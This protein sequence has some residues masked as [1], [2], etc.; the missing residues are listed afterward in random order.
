M[1]GSSPLARGTLL[2][3][4]DLEAEARLIP[5]RAGNMQTLIRTSTCSSAHPRSRGE[6]KKRLRV[7]WTLSRLIPARAGNIHPRRSPP[8]TRTA[9][10]RSRGEHVCIL[11]HL[12]VPVGSSP[13][14]RGTFSEHE[15]EVRARRLIPAR[16]GNI[17]QLIL[18]GTSDAA[19][20]RSRGEHLGLVGVQRDPCGSSP[21]ARGT[22]AYDLAEKIHERLIPARAGNIIFCVTCIMWKTAHPRSRGEHPKSS[23]PASC[24][25]GSSP[26]ARG[27]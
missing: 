4:T 7:W 17:P 15:D 22:W 8:S 23:A 27:T 12:M 18:H 16:A 25:A 6:H 9:H 11:L 10:P 19:H 20:P 5:A 24:C 1:N 26:L 13:L 14:A 2:G 21:L 3:V